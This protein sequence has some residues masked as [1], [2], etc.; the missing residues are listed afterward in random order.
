MC[1]ASKHTRYNKADTQSCNT[2]GNVLRNGTIIK[3]RRFRFLRDSVES[4]ER[5]YWFNT[6]LKD[7]KQLRRFIET[8]NHHT[9]VFVASSNNDTT[10]FSTFTLVTELS[11]VTIWLHRT[12]IINQTCNSHVSLKTRTIRGTATKRL[13]FVLTSWIGPAVENN[14][15]SSTRNNIERTIYIYIH[16]IYNVY[17]LRYISF[18]YEY[19]FH[20]DW[21]NGKDEVCL[22]K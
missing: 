17:S 5:N 20:R 3:C 22:M 7:L 12:I 19:F 13:T 16:I 6:D 1:K 4:I 9:S 21:K 15:I 14:K 10:I 2:I 8:A 18:V 11:L